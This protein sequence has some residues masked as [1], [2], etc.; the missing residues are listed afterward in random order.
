LG[1]K[2]SYLSDYFKISMEDPKDVPNTY[3][4]SLAPR[5]LSMRKRMQAM[6][7]WVDRDTY[8]PKQVCWVERS[9]DSWLLELGS[10]QLNAPLPQAVTGF[11]V[12]AGVS[13]RSG[14]SFFATRKK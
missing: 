7:I 4:L 14:F 5:S 10:L 9:G 2:L 1:Q 3:Y 8:L 13:L 6:Y 12:P 11:K